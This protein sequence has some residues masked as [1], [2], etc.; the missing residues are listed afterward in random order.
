MIKRTVP[1]KGGK[2]HHVVIQSLNLFAFHISLSGSSTAL[3]ALNRYNRSERLKTKYAFDLDFD[4]YFNTRDYSFCSKQSRKVLVE[5][6]Y[7]FKLPGGP[8]NKTPKNRNAFD[9]E[10]EDDEDIALGNGSYKLL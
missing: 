5:S 10:D 6:L 1:K 2:F 8:R 7:F 9:E 3:T 4:T